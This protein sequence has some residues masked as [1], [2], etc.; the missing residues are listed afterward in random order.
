M[1]AAQPVYNAGQAT[2]ILRSDQFLMF[3]VLINKFP[4]IYVKISYIY[5]SMIS[6]NSSLTCFKKLLD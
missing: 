6:E 5:I 1:F 4:L 2:H 3:T